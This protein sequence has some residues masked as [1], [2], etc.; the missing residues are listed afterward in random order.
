M[1]KFY[2]D[3]QA[4]LHIHTHIIYIYIHTYI[5]TH[6]YI[7]FVR[8]NELTIT[9]VMI[10]ELGVVPSFMGGTILGGISY[11]EGVVLRVSW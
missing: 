11:F 5:Y 6:T 8:P 3:D 9:M 2:N 10:I 1:C 7:F 4:R